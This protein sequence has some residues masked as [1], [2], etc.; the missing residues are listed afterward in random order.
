M[1]NK[2]DPRSWFTEAE[3]CPGCLTVARVAMAFLNYRDAL[4]VVQTEKER[5]CLFCGDLIY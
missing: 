4:S 2:P 5:R 3:L 1:R